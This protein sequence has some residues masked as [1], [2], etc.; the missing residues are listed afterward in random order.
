MENFQDIFNLDANDF[1][2]KTETRESE[3]YKPD[4]KKGKD[5]V[6]K[7]LVRFTPFYKDPKKSKVK[8]YSY[9]LTDP[10]T[11][12]SFSVDCPSSIN[13]KSILQDTY[14]K[15]KKSPSVAEQKLADKFKRRENYYALVQILKD[16][17][18]PSTIGKIKVLKFGQKLNNIIQSEL[19]PEYGKPY[20]PFDPFKGRVM[21]L[22]VSIVAGYN[23]YDLSKFVGDE[24]PLMLDG[25][26]LESSPEQMAKFVEFLKTNSPD[27]S[28]YDYKEWTDDVREK[29]KSVIENTVPTMRTTESIRTEASRP[30]NI[31]VASTHANIEAEA[32][33]KV[34]MEDLNLDLDDSSDFEDD[35]Y[36]GL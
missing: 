2:E 14:W 35:L 13:Q 22:T 25:K 9:W 17:Q 24:T 23:N 8:K 20:N 3:L 26:P 15:L 31:S 5:N 19:Q 27:L 34:E 33:K 7:A 28:N 4:P 16:D 12:D 32:S 1:V 29:V 36:S 10:L 11:S 18:D 6:Y 30:T 21:A